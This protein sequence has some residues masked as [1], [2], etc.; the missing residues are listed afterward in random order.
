MTLWR[1]EIHYDLSCQKFKNWSRKSRV[2]GS[3][4]TAFFVRRLKKLDFPIP[5]L[6]NCLQSVIA[7]KRINRFW[8][9]WCQSLA[10]SKL[11]IIHI[12]KSKIEK[13]IA[14]Y[15]FCPC[16]QH[17]TFAGYWPCF[18]F[19]QHHGS[20]CSCWDRDLGPLLIDSPWKSTKIGVWMANLPSVLTAFA[21]RNQHG[22]NSSDPTEPI[23]K[24]MTERRAATPFQESWWTL[25]FVLFTLFP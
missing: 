14:P 10:F 21:W 12:K 19:I 9:A 2:M 5:I 11:Y 6:T 1:K 17:A 18:L 15:G 8:G 4:R 20:E 25:I 13:E 22:P 16:P 24:G 7:P 3:K 23:R